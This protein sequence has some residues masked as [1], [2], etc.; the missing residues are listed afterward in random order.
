[1]NSTFQAISGYYLEN[2]S[3]TS[4]TLPERLMIAEVAP[5]F[6]E[7][8]GVA[9]RFGRDFTPAE[10]HFGGPNAALISDRLWRRR[11]ATDPAVIGKILHLEGWAFPIV[12]VMPANFHFPDKDADIWRPVPMDAPYAQD[13]KSTWFTAIGRMKPGITVVRARADLDTVQA[14]LARQFPRTD[15]NVTSEVQPLKDIT[16]SASRRSLWIL[17]GSVSLLLLIACTNI[18]ALLLSRTTQRQRE[19]SIR[20]SLGAS[21]ASVIEQL[22]TEVLLL[23][24]L[25]S[26]AGLL[27]SAGAVRI[28]HSLARALPRADEIGLDWRVVSYTL[29]CAILTTLLCGLLPA[30]IASRRSISSMLAADSRSQVSGRA[31]LQWSLVGV[32]VAL[33]VT[34]LVGAGLLL[35]SFQ[36]LGR[37]YPGFDASDVLTL[38]ISGNYGETGN[39]KKLHQR[40][41]R[42][43]E[44]LRSVPGVESA[45]LSVSLPGIA[46]GY[47]GDLKS[48]DAAADPDRKITADQKFVSAGYFETLRIPLLAGEACKENSL[49][50]SVVVN[51]SFV[52]TYFPGQPAIGHHLAMTPNP[53]QTPPAPILGIV[54]DARENGLNRQPVPTAYWCSTNGIPDPYFVIRTHG[55]PMSFAN[56]LRQK[57]HRI[58][59]RRSV[60]EVM[61]LQQHLLDSTAE[62][63]FRTL[64]LSLFALTAISLAAIGLYGTLSYLVALRNREIGLR[65]ALGALPGQIATRYLA[66]GL[67]ISLLGCLAGLGVAAALS[68]LL[69]GMLYGVSRVDP[70]TYL[71]VAAGALA[72]AALASTVPARRAARLDPMQTLRHD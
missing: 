12:G 40:M 35:R 26:T 71:G 16:V 14:Q 28:F 57:V 5:R 42:T 66:Q 68:R 38:R 18:A 49:W 37:V 10:E 64:L 50:D 55:D 34:L 46:E 1:M 31:P 21:R 39:Q 24:L 22:L 65:M 44:A 41:L 36:E 54:A 17:F 15:K 20:Y 53:F 33:A 30:L 43:L 8:L 72:V 59:P 9:P 7:V 58:E 4:G 19:I 62:S 13:R 51:S 23:A 61:P 60:F 47:P 69:T 56:V 52:N 70:T 11:F 25:G 3:E 27:I 32:Q 63:R 2:V 45:A 67:G 6:F 29:A 48:T